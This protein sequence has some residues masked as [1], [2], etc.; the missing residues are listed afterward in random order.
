M[1]PFS[2]TFSGFQCKPHSP[3]GFLLNDAKGQCFKGWQLQAFHL[4]RLCEPLSFL[5]ETSWRNY[6]C[7]TG[8]R[9]GRRSGSLVLFGWQSV[10]GVI[11]SI[12]SLT[13][14]VLSISSNDKRIVGKE[15]Y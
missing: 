9:K 8:I 11:K 12:V 13:E 3:Y 6:Q 7:K 2:S 4:Q 10:Q 15:L 14:R 5:T 1:W